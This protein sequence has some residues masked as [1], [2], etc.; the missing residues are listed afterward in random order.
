VIIYPVLG[1]F[2]FSGIQE[3]LSCVFTGN[4]HAEAAR[5]LCAWQLESNYR[6]RVRLALTN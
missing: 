6:G 4:E 3:S 5:V 1:K 2:R